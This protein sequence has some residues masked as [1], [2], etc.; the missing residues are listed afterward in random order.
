MFEYHEFQFAAPGKA[1][2]TARK[3]NSNRGSKDKQIDGSECK[4]SDK[5]RP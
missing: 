4:K 2:V 5:K 3:A 1:D